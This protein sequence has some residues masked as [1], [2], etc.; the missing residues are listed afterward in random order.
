MAISELTCTNHLQLTKYPVCS[1]EGRLQVPYPRT[2][3]G[4]TYS[5]SLPSCVSV[6]AA[7]AARPVSVRVTAT[8]KVNAPSPRTTNLTAHCIAVRDRAT[9]SVAHYIAHR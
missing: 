3:Q 8:V 5:P 7:A 2:F 9:R 4:T 6:L 1:K